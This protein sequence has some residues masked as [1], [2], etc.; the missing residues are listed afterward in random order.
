MP[1]DLPV[2]SG[3]SEGRA[4]RQCC[5]EVVPRR[6]L[7]TEPRAPLLLPP[8][9]SRRVSTKSPLNLPCQAAPGQA[10]CRCWDLTLP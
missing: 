1:S 4:G 7:E 3:D 8:V 9:T 2:A 5:G 10:S 6:G